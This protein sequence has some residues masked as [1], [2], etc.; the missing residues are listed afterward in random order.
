VLGAI[1]IIVIVVL[2][3]ALWLRALVDVIRRPDLDLA[4]KIVWPVAMLVFPFIGLMIYTLLRPG[5][6]QIAQR[7]QR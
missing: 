6:S 2:F 7:A 4:M 5:D 3:L 1:V